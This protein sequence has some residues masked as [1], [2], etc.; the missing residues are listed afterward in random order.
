MTFTMFESPEL[1]QLPN[2]GIDGCKRGWIGVFRNAG[3]GDLR[4]FVIDHIAT[5]PHDRFGCIAIDIPIGLPDFG[6]RLCDTQARKILWHRGCCVFPAPI[7]SLLDAPT[8]S[9]AC[10]RREA[11]EGKRVSKQAWHIFTKIEQVDIFLRRNRH[12]AN[13]VYEVHPEV[14]FCKMNKGIPLDTKKSRSTGKAER[15]ELVD[16]H[17]GEGTF[18]RLKESL[19][20]GGWGDDDLLDACAA[21][22]SAERI[23]FGVAQTLPEFPPHDSI[24]LPMRIVF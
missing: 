8:Y 5:L 14:S 17:F 20:P 16:R 10:A 15:R 12:L 13:K 6:S 2:V 23:A 7:R 11:A 24:G 4:A 19:V 22:W 3:V 18:I 9:D 1:D 21:L